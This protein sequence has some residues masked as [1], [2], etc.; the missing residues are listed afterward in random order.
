MCEIIDYKHGIQCNTIAIIYKYMY[1]FESQT[2][3]CWHQQNVQH[4]INIFFFFIIIA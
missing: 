1:T 2:N 3:V 4:V